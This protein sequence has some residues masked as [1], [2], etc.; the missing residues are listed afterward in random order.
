[1]SNSDVITEK[2]ARLI[3]EIK[4]LRYLVGVLLAR[5]GLDAEGIQRAFELAKT[6]TAKLDEEMMAVAREQF[7]ATPEGRAAHERNQEEW[8]RRQQE[9]WRESCVEDGR[10]YPNPTTLDRK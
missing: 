9:V 7:L 4:E 8:N 5:S 6:E 2:E 3:Q 10:I 1:M